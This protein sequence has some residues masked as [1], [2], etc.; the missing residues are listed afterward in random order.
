MRTRPVDEKRCPTCGS[1]VLE[2]YAAVKIA[3]PPFRIERIFG[4]SSG[5]PTCGWTEMK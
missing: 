4:H 5:N 3:G 1:P 2:Y